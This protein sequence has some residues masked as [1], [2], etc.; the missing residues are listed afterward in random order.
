MELLSFIIQSLSGLLLLYV[1]IKRIS[2]PLKT[3]SQS[4]GI[5]FENDVNVLS[6]LKGIGAV[7]L[8]G[9]IVVILG[10][11]LNQYSVVTFVV[12]SLIFM[13]VAIGRILSMVLD[14]KPNTKLMR[15]FVIEL[16]FGILNVIG[17][18]LL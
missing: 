8:F 14:G 15:G 2:N 13:G 18:I 3:Y 6:E 17:L 4:F 11:I 9:G 10:V 12:G 16:L 1:G 5:E 7:M